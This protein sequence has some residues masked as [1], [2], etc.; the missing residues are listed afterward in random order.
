MATALLS[1]ALLGCG[2]AAP[3]A[4]RSPVVEPRV[5]PPAPDAEAA[6]VVVEPVILDTPEEVAPV[7]AAA[8][9][10]RIGASGDLL[11]HIRVLASAEAH[12]GFEHVLGP[13]RAAIREDEIAFLNLETPLSLERPVLSGS[14]PILGAPPEVAQVMA[15]IGID[16]V[17]VANNHA[18]DQHSVGAGR[19]LEALAS[20]G[21]VALG[22]GPD[23][24]A[25]FAPRVVIA[26]DGS[27]VAFVGITERVNGG[28][29]PLGPSTLIARWADDAPVR[30]ALDLA[31]AQADLVVV[32]IHWSHDFRALPMGTQ[33]ERA[34]WLVDHGADV[35]IGHGP[36]VLQ[37]VDRLTS[38]RGEAVCA[39][40]LGNLVSNQGFRYARGR[41]AARGANIATWL[42]ASRDG[43]WLRIEARIEDGRVTIAPIT[44]V[45]LF[46]YN[47]YPERERDRHALEDVR[48]QLLDDIADPLLRDERR[49]IIAATLG[50]HVTLESSATP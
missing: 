11:A 24:P 2:A 21:V 33:R 20:A 46:T 4:S 22:G 12:G 25:A 15:S 31:R 30:E 42:A 1:I 38:P 14:P 47:N 44:G 49:A 16:V 29:G 48:I 39:Y 37:E 9:V 3:H 35:I 50:R 43:V 13:L 10:I 32:S 23:L 6:D 18:W 5:E 45:P 19:T 27:R 28:P 40:S 8:R 36:H 34:Q 17:S 7:P 41:R 26:A